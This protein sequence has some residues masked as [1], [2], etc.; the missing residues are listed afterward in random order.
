MCILEEM[1]W[2]RTR[3]VHASDFFHGTLEL[4]EEG[5]SVL[6]LKGEDASRP[7]VE[8]VEK[9]APNYTDKVCVLDAA[10]HALPGISDDA[11]ALRLTGAARHGP[12]AAERAP[13]GPAGPPAH[14]PALLQARRVLRRGHRDERE[15]HREGVRAAPGRHG[16]APS[17]L[18]VGDNV[19]DRYVEAG[20]M[21]PG[22]NAVN[23]AVHAR[24]N[25]ATSAYLG[26]VGTDRAGQVVLAAL[27]EEGVDTTLTR[28]VDGPNAYA[29]VRVVDGN[30]VFGGADV[31]ISR[32]ALGQDDLAAA[33]A[34]DVVH[35][36]ECSMVEEQLQDLA[37]AARI[38]SFDFSERPWDYVQ[39]HAPKVSVAIWS[40]PGGDRAS[41]EDR[42]A[43][44]RELGPSV[45]AITMGAGGAVLLRDGT[46]AYSPVAAGTDRGHPR[47]R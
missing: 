41:A 47:G 28:Q 13:G 29:D 33:A 7:L 36:G 26:A 25:G 3:P 40:M 19:V 6:L 5:V 24:R 46:F 9:F 15:S 2:I 16:A 12:G 37:D 35:T 17:L 23:V 18:A 14:H 43:R 39:T 11:R 4:V 44:L 31:G 30:R 45:V 1:Q 27:E 42:A 34:F 22:G 21:Y 38:L 10:D 32:F 20:Y 8:R